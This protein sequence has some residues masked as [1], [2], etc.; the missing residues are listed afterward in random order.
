M[1]RRIFVGPLN[2]LKNIKAFLYSVKNYYNNPNP[3]SISQYAVS[4]A[5]MV[6]SPFSDDEPD[7][8]FV[9]PEPICTGCATTATPTPT[10]TLTPTPTP[11]ATPPV[12]SPTPTPSSS[13]NFG[14]LGFTMNGLVP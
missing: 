6:Y 5:S 9:C 13:Y 1:T 8:T 3:D 12:P 11:T 4:S 7:D 2:S 10:P 14:P